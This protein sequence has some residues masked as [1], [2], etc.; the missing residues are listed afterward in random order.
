MGT[1][2]VAILGI[3]GLCVLYAIGFAVAVW[4]V[5]NARERGCPRWV[6]LTV[7]VLAVLCWPF[8]LFVWLVVR[9]ARATQ[10]V[11]VVRET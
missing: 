1:D 11:A 5:A 7:G 10:T 8:V 4:C 3:W 9:P 6:A 2:I